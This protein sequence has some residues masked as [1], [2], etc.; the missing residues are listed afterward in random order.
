M[1]VVI[2]CVFF[3]FLFSSR[4][5]IGCRYLRPGKP[6]LTKLPFKVDST[7]FNLFNTSSVSRTL[8]QSLEQA[9]ESILSTEVEVTMAKRK[10]DGELF[11]KKT[12]CCT[13]YLD[14]VSGVWYYSCSVPP[15]QFLIHYSTGRNS[16]SSPSPRKL[17][18]PSARPSW[19]TT[20]LPTS[21]SGARARPSTSTR[22]SSVPG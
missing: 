16:S 2:V 1:K 5:G 12:P 4:A 13:W 7:Q 9:L 14:Q 21:S 10:Q 19:R 17:S 15:H 6:N 11:I 20:P 18:A 3:Y 8:R 22:P